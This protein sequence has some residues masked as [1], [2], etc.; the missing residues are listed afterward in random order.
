M[1]TFS[2]PDPASSPDGRRAFEGGFSHR[3]RRSGLLYVCVSLPLVTIAGALAHGRSSYILVFVLLASGAYTT[4]A[5]VVTWLAWRRSPAGDR[6]HA[7]HVTTSAG[8]V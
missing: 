6:R 4:P 5:L 8:V 3:L 1:A 2:G 7:S